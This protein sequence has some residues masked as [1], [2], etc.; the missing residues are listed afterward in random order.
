MKTLTVALTATSIALA[1]T[2]VYLWR[3]LE[4]ERQ[5]VALAEAALETARTA[6][7]VV[8]AHEP[9]ED[10]STETA[11]PNAL[12]TVLPGARVTES[13]A[14]EFPTEAPEARGMRRERMNPYATTQGREMMRLMNKVG[15]KR[16]YADLI[17]Q[18]GLK[19]S[20]AEALLNALADQQEREFEAIRQARSSG[21]GRMDR[22]AMES[23]QRDAQ[24]Q[25]QAQ[26]ASVLGANTAQKLSDYQATLGE[27]MQVQ[28]L[29][30]QLDAFGLALSDQQEEQ[31]IAAMTEEKAAF[32][33]PKWNWDD[34][35]ARETNLEWREQFNRRVLARATSILSSEQH[36][37]I[38]EIQTWQT[39]LQRQ[40]MNR[41]QRPRGMRPDNPG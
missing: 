28:Q 30:E 14:Q 21:Q 39:S 15:N 31:M 33:Q 32:P 29:S 1:G 18:L 23:V 7:P 22:E 11:G 3:Q 37:Q 38:S 35:K 20:E 5:R 26:V 10:T 40:G 36:R 9:I 12:A 27:R 8:P 41:P 4:G 19:D 17:K 6:V 24:T 13:G 2:S 16:A 25:T 34:P